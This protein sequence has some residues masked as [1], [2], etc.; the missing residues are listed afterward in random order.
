[1]TNLLKRFAIEPEAG[2]DFT[3]SHVHFGR[4]S[5]RNFQIFEM[6][7]GRVGTLAIDA[8]VA[9]PG[10]APLFLSSKPM[11]GGRAWTSDSVTAQIAQNALPDSTTFPCC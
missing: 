2:H 10:T 3:R 4:S 6:R 11:I 8:P 5:G 7:S 9:S 1:M